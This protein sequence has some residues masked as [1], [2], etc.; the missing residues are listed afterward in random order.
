MITGGSARLRLKN[1]FDPASLSAL[2]LM[3][4]L[5]ILPSNNKSLIESSCLCSLTE[6]NN[7][8]SEEA[9]SSWVIIAF[10]SIRRKHE[11]ASNWSGSRIDPLIKSISKAR[12]SNLNSTCEWFRRHAN[13]I[14]GC[15]ILAREEKERRK[16]NFNFRVLGK[17]KPEIRP[18]K[19]NKAKY[20]F[21][22][23]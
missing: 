1:S 21:S 10:F 9:F 23:T 3:L 6:E 16:I 18:L 11:K 8:S 5:L 20:N 14:S 4:S 7:L 13:I 12:A 15:A 17:A 22:A 2:S 19:H